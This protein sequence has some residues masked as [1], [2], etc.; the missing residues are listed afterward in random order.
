MFSTVHLATCVQCIQ[1]NQTAAGH[2]EPKEITSDNSWLR[3]ILMPVL[4]RS[5]LAV[6]DEFLH[7]AKNWPFILLH[8][9]D[10]ESVQPGAYSKVQ[11]TT[12]LTWNSGFVSHCA[13]ELVSKASHSPFFILAGVFRFCQTG[14]NNVI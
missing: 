8:Q 9:P 5:C 12:I 14:R 6:F 10:F 3:R 7:S 1:Y 4:S 2:T 11:M 13:L